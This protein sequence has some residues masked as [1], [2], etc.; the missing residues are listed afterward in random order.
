M[1][2]HRGYP[3]PETVLPCLAR[4]GQTIQYAGIQP[5]FLMNRQAGD[6][7][8]DEISRPSRGSVICDQPP[9]WVF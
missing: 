6:H 5:N 3:P 2:T 8:A 4:E 1:A 9:V 7:R